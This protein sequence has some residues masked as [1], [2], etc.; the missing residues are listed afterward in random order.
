M[1][2]VRIVVQLPDSAL[3]GFTESGQGLDVELFER[4]GALIEG[5][6]KLKRAI[7]TSW[8]MI[9]T[10]YEFSQTLD[11]SSDSKVVYGSFL[12]SESEGW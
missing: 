4:Y 9:S 12:S 7:V 1:T 11:I 5:A 2:Y 10:R 3:G 6:G 8:L